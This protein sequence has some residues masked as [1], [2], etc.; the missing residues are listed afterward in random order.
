MG[1]KLFVVLAVVL[2]VAG[3]GDNG[4]PYASGTLPPSNGNDVGPD[5]AP[6]LGPGQCWIGQDC[7]RGEACKPSE[8]IESA[9]KNL[10]I[11]HTGTP[12]ECETPPSQQMVWV[13][14]VSPIRFEQ[15]DGSLDPSSDDFVVDHGLFDIELAVEVQGTTQAVEGGFELPAGPGEVP[16]FGF[17]WMVDMRLRVVDP[18]DPDYDVECN[19][20]FLRGGDALGGVTRGAGVLVCSNDNWQAAE[21]AGDPGLLIEFEIVPVEPLPAPIDANGKMCSSAELSADA[22]SAVGSVACRSFSGED[23][24]MFE[25]VVS[26]RPLGRIGAETTFEVQAQLVH[27]EDLV[28]QYIDIADL[29]NAVLADAAVYLDQVN[30]SSPTMLAVDAPCELD[31][32]RDPD[33]D[34]T[35]GPVVMTTETATA[36][37]TAVDGSITVEATD[38]AFRLA[39][40][41]EVHVST[42]PSAYGTPV[43]DPG[44]TWL[45]VPRL[46]FPSND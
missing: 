31:Y 25:V 3:C 38:I 7:E 24:P 46:T 26:A 19:L 12:G 43:A 15:G 35:P 1:Y 9:A 41:L 6:K 10:S 21:D 5:G 44:C 14:G 40:P 8:L 4:V 39:Q 23:S 27:P 22:V 36:V 42:D 17:F 30:G 45:E 37:W 20:R 13:T 18:N 16:G 28:I 29:E 33:E 32:S 2:M 34:G 11:T